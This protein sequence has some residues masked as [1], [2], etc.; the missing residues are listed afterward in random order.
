MN[1]KRTIQVVRQSPIYFALIN[2]YVSN[3]YINYNKATITI[4]L[5]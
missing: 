3:Y 5:P 4:A 1:T 2:P